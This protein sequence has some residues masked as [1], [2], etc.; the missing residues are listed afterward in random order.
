[1]GGSLLQLMEYKTQDLFLTGTPQMTFFKSVYKRHTHFAMESIKQKIT[2][3]TNFGDTF[4][5]KVSKTG[6]L[7]TKCY[8]QCTLT[9]S[10]ISD[11]DSISFSDVPYVRELGHQLIDSVEILIGGQT[12]DKHYGIWLSIWNSLTMT[13]EQKEGYYKMIGNIETFTGKKPNSSVASTETVDYSNDYDLYIPLQFWFCRHTGLALPLIALQYH[14]VQF[15]VKFNTL[16]NLIKNYASNKFLTPPTLSNTSFYIDYIYLDSDEK[17]RFA[18]TSQEYIIDQLQINTFKNIKIRPTGSLVNLNFKNL[19]KELI[20]VRNVYSFAE[21]PIDFSMPHIEGLSNRDAM[22]IENNIK[23]EYI[24]INNQTIIEQ[25][26]NF[27]TKLQPLQCHTRVPYRKGINVYSFSL[28]P[29]E[30]QPSGTCN[31]NN[32]KCSISWEI[33]RYITGTSGSLYNVYVFALSV[34]ILRISG[35][36]ST[37]SYSI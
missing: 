28:K 8:I 24:R 31:F 26:E 18:T 20:W 12:I 17:K 21:S 30:S 33:P 3:N 16:N 1:M 13:E 7:I 14:E 27:F 25:N 11:L 15:I 22:Y 23:K 34:N 2:G 36:T 4:K 19:V 9:G 29:E 32:L 5:V 6:D 10:T 35:G 37:L